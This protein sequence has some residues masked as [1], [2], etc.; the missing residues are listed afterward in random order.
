[1]DE[2]HEKIETLRKEVDSLNLEILKLLNQR[3]KF[4]LD[5][6]HLKKDTGMPIFDPEREE[7]QLRIIKE[8]NTGPMLD[9]EIEEIFETILRQSKTFGRL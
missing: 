7:E 9:E 2:T 3:K 6:F 4:I 8:K 1:M 5:I